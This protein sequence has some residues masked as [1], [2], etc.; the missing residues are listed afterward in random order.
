MQAVRFA[1]FF[2]LY[3]LPR[4]AAASSAVRRFTPAAVSGDVTLDYALDEL[5][6]R[7][8]EFEPLASRYLRQLRGR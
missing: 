5:T 3:T 4:S 6:R 8:P 7:A 2:A 1:S